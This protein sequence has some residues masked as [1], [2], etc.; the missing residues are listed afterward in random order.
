MLNQLALLIMVSLFINGLAFADPTVPPN[1]PA[2]TQA[3]ETTTVYLLNN[4]S[5]SAEDFE[6]LL[7]Q[8]EEIP[9]TSYCAEESFLDDEGKEIGGGTTGYDG[10]D[11]AGKKF[12]YTSRTEPEGTTH[13]L[14]QLER[15]D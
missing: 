5:L 7:S 12:R 3:M 10:I 8:L 2:K 1:N 15:G 11:K 6:R 9:N 13:S 14:V 4:Q